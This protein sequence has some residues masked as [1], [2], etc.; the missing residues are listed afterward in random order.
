MEKVIAF[1][2]ISNMSCFEES[3]SGTSNKNVNT[4]NLMFY[5]SSV[6]TGL[7]VGCVSGPPVL[8]SGGS[9]E[10]VGCH[11]WWG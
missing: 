8:G 10:A 4:V 1:I 7:C 2:C 9:S 11:T 6:L 5:K 3:L